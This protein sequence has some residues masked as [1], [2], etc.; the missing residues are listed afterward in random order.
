[1]SMSDTIQSGRAIGGRANVYYPY[2]IGPATGYVKKNPS[3]RIER[4]DTTYWRIVYDPC[5]VEMPDLRMTWQDVK[6]MLRCR[7]LVL[8]TILENTSTGER[9]KVVRSKHYRERGYRLVAHG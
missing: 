5:E 7:S 6:C 4:C 1:M 3:E 2:T 8:G 9:L